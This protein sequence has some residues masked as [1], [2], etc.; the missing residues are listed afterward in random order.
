MHSTSMDYQ[1]LLHSMQ[2][3]VSELLQLMQQSLRGQPVDE[4]VYLKAFG[5]KEG[6]VPQLQRLCSL[7]EEMKAIESFND[8]NHAADGISAY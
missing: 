5:S 2:G 3:L 7:M 1:P 4:A 8:K 6:M